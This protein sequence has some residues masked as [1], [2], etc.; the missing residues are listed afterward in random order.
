MRRILLFL[1]LVV[2]T[3]TATAQNSDS[4]DV[5]SGKESKKLKL[6]VPTIK[7]QMGKDTRVSFLCAV[8][9]WRNAKKRVDWL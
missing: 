2:I 8:L 1:L 4:L 9:R 6:E 3:I 5:K 7:T